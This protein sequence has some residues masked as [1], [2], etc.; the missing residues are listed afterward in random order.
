MDWWNC[1]LAVF[2]NNVN[3]SKPNKCLVLFDKEK[4]TRLKLHIYLQ[5]H[6]LWST[7]IVL[8]FC[9]MHVC[10]IELFTFGI[11]ISFIFCWTS[12]FF[13]WHC[14]LWGGKPAKLCA[15]VHG[16][17]SITLKGW[18]YPYPLVPCSV[19]MVGN[20]FVQIKWLGVLSLCFKHPRTPFFEPWHKNLNKLLL[21]TNSNTG[22]IS[23]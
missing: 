7:K 12:F 3:L 17:E 13:V 10:T 18:C 2:W 15:K 4:A 5:K 23:S 14:S 22:C 1:Y 16:S 9:L 19:A 20:P 6:P 11:W 21:Q 8:M